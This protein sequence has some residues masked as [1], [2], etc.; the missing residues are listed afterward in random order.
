MECPNC[1]VTK[2]LKGGNLYP[3]CDYCSQPYCSKTCLQSDRINHKTN[4]K[5][6]NRRQRE[7]K[8][9]LDSKL[10]RDFVWKCE[11]MIVIAI[12]CV[13]YYNQTD[14]QSVRNDRKLIRQ[15]YGPKGMNYY[16][17][18]TSTDFVSKNLVGTIV[19]DVGQFIM[20]K[21][22]GVP[23]QIDGV[24]VICSGHGDPA[25]LVTSEDNNVS[26]ADIYN[27]VSLS[28]QKVMKYVPPFFFMN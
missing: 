15:M 9:Y 12:C 8:V 6:Y 22:D 17:F 13:T 14:L 19:E 7:I 25:I 4:N 5:C 20:G 21:I 23:K 26:L 16:L 1:H 18:I 24:V 11:E 2:P 28:I 27:Q 10:R 3:T